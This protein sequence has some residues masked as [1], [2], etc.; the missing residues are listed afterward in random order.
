ME[1]ECNV[2]TLNGIEYTEINRVDKNGNTYVL[3]S[4]LDKPT[5]FC[6]KKIVKKDGIDYINGLTNEQEFNEILNLVTE[7]FQN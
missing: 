1:K 3:L 7:K 6:I 5:D 4:N 2:V